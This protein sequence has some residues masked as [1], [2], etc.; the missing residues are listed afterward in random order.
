M[1]RPPSYPTSRRSASGPRPRPSGSPCP[2]PPAA[3]AGPQRVWWTRRLEGSASIRLV[4]GM[5]GMPRAG[6]KFGPRP[7]I[8]ER[9][10][11]VALNGRVTLISAVSPAEKIE[12]MGS[13]PQRRHTYGKDANLRGVDGG[14][15]AGAWLQYT[16]E[17]GSAE[18]GGRKTQFQFGSHPDGA[19]WP[20]GGEAHRVQDRDANH[21][22]SRCDDLHRDEHGRRRP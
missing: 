20:G 5:L 11:S 1:T 17:S 3:R 16:A 7:S 18:A 2:E 8:D 19:K 4:E 13:I 12:V 22:P 21:T 10:K 14:S 6:L 9:K 15:G